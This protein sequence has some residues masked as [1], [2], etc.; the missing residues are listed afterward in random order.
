[1]P[2]VLLCV[3]G[4][5]D[6]RSMISR[7]SDGFLAVD[8]VGN[9]AWLYERQGNVGSVVTDHDDS[10]VYPVGTE[11]GERTLDWD[12]VP[13]VADSPQVIP[14]VEAEEN[15]AGQPVDD[16]WDDEEEQGPPGITTKP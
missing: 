1:M 11:T 9:R 16:G 14:V 3:G 2:E 15:F 8:A 10:L 4:P 5:L 6:G 7:T 12:R 13:V